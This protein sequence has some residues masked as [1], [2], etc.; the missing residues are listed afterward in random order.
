[1]EV[2]SLTKEEFTV[3]F[4]K[5]QQRR[6]KMLENDFIDFKSNIRFKTWKKNKKR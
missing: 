4:L 3:R 5:E 2:I 1:M 6:K